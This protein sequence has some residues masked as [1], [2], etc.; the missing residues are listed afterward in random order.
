MSEIKATSFRINEEDND[1]FKKFASDNGFNNQA[2]AFKAMVQIV[3]MAR[4]KGQIKGRAKEIEVFQ[5][6]IN[7]LMG[8]F[9][10]SLNVNQS[11]EETIRQE[12]SQELLAK[13]NS[14]NTMYEQLKKS[15]DAIAE[16]EKG[17][18]DKSMELEKVQETIK[19]YIEKN[20]T[21]KKDLEDKQKS[22]DVLTRN[23]F[24]QI[25]QLDQYKDLKSANDLLLKQ[26][27]DYNSKL[28]S[29][30]NEK[31]QLENKINNFIEMISFHKDNIADLKENVEQYKEEIKD[32]NIKNDKRIDQIRSES[33]Q[34]EEKYK[35]Q[36]KELKVEF[37]SVTKKEIE[38]I[39]EQLNNKYLVSLEKKDLENEKLKNQIDKLKINVKNTKNTSKPKDVKQV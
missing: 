29:L 9:L 20:N 2:E 28:L 12:L 16:M 17:F 33:L 21:L 14:I 23:N 6:T 30:T 32:L 31:E 8:Y 18:K 25:E 27:E 10:N 1:I 19:E 11:S 39:K 4:A 5:N 15:N 24:N 35:T 7:E 13:D 38:S 3:E 36:I 22:I 26:L 37:D 34:M